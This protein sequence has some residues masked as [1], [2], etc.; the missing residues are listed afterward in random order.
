MFA[1]VY[2]VENKPLKRREAADSS[3]AL[4]RAHQ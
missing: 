4:I 3:F 1:Y 2:H